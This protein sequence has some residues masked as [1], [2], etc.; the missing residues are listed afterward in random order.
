MATFKATFYPHTEF[1]HR[2]ITGSTFIVAPLSGGVRLTDLTTSGSSQVVQ[3]DGADWVA[4]VDGVLSVV[5]DGAYNIASGEAPV[6][7]ATAGQPM[8]ADA[9][10]F[11]FAIT[12]GHKV[13]VIDA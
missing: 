6:A 11:P 2:A 3:Y 7:S 10:P 4:N 12:A 5:C 8:P 9:G 13:A 1:T